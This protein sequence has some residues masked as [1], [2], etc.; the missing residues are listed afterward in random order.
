MLRKG[1]T[2][3]EKSLQDRI[4]SDRGLSLIR[5]AEEAA[6]LLKDGMALG[7]CSFTTSGYPKAVP[8]ALIERKKRGEDLGF[9]IISGA[10]VGPEVDAMMVEAGLVRRRVPYSQSVPLRKAIN[11]GEIAYTDMHLSHSSQY[12][13]YGFLGKIDMALV[14]AVAITEEGDL[15]LSTNV[16]NAPNLIRKAE[17][18]IVEVSLTKPLAMEGMHDIVTLAPPPDREPIPIV[19]PGDRIG[20]PYV[21]CGWDKIRA[22]VLSELTDTPR[23]IPAPDEVSLKIAENVIRFLE[24]EIAAGRLTKRLLPLQSGV[25]A[26]A[27]AVLQGLLQSDFEHL[28]CYTEV[29]QDAMLDLIRSGK[30][31]EASSTSITLSPEGLERFYREIDSFRDKIVLRPQEISNHPEVIRRLGL[32]SMN[33]ALEADIYGN[34]NSTHVLGR[35]MMNGIGGSGDFA[36]N[37][38]YTIF[39]T[40][41]VAKG[42]AISAIVPMCAHVDH[43]EHDVMVLVTEYG[44]ADLRGLSPKERPRRIIENCA[45]PDYREALL[46]YFERACRQEPCQTPHI[47]REALSWHQRLEETGTMRQ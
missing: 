8:L 39:T 42:G 31:E 23:P 16:G 40:P 15:L 29:V 44:Y 47:L 11:R 30:V 21:K 7:V 32:I 20:S 35:R 43:T 4:R 46:D 37:A 9:D 10:T 3:M 26:V 14:E 19:R 41:S 27:N 18:V 13:D 22:I 12:I 34:V 17:G 33:T 6:G 24:G 25:G 5:T 45:H 2:R 28:T 1:F 38:A 36:R